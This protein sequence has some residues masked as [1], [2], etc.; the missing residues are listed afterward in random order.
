MDSGLEAAREFVLR[1]MAEVLAA[2]MA[3]Q[4]HR[5]YKSL[6]QQYAQRRWNT[7]PQYDLLDEKGPE[8][9][10]CFEIAV[11]ISGRQYPS[12]WGRFKKQAEQKAALAALQE[13]GV[14]E[15]AESEAAIEPEYTDPPADSAGTDADNIAHAGGGGGAKFVF[16][17]LAFCRYGP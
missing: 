17:F 16:Y 2:A 11:R 4:H 13:L 10:K 9:A 5:N 14:L 8:H 1:E 12:A 3:S 7:T 6:L 15:E